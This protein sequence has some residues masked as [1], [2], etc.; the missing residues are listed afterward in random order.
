MRLFKADVTGHA[1]PAVGRTFD[2]FELIGVFPGELSAN[3]E[4]AIGRAIVD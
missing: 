2:Q 3:L 4:A 1:D